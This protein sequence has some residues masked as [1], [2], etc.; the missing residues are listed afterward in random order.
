MENRTVSLWINQSEEKS[1]TV[2][3]SINQS[4]NVPCQRVRKRDKPAMQEEQ[5]TTVSTFIG[6]RDKPLMEKNLLYVRWRNFLS[7]NDVFNEKIQK[8]TNY[9]FQEI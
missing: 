6:K 3:L 1:R 2:S 5:R 7:N 9:I 4:G 8:V